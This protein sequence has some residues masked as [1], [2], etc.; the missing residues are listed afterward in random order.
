M[1]RDKDALRPSPEEAAAAL[2]AAQ[3]ASSAGYT[4][5]PAWFFPT[6]GLLVGGVLM[7][8]A[9]HEIVGLAL[10][11]ALVVGYLAIER[12]YN[13]QVDRSGVAPRELTM[14][15]QLVL[16]APL[17]LLWIA[18]QLLDDRW[19]PV[20]WVVIAVTGACWTIG[21]GILHNRRA[22]ERARASA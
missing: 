15:Q 8:Q 4:P 10:I 19:G 5:I 20:V 13:K 11:V 12:V 3:Q 21:Y 2:K 22:R 18:G 14:R 17:L 7:L 6:L 16:A 1:E 9:L